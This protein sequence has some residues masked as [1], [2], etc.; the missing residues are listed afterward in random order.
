[1]QTRHAATV[2]PATDGMSKVTALAVSSLRIA[3]ATTDRVVLLYDA[4]SGE[5]RDRIPT[6]AGAAPGG[7]AGG[8][9]SVSYQVRG[10][11]FSPDGVRL[12][13][14]QSD[15][16]VFVFKLGAT[17]GEKKSI[18]NKFLQQQPVTA[19]TWPP[20]SPSTLYIGMADGRVKAGSLRTNKSS[21]IYAGDAF[22]Y[23]LASA[24][25]ADDAPEAAGASRT[26]VVAGHLDGT[27]IVLAEASKRTLA[28]HPCPP[29]ALAVSS[30]AVC[31]AGND[32][33]VVLYALHSGAIV[34]SFDF[35]ADAGAH[36]F[37][38]AAFN[39][40][41]STVAVGSFDC[42][43]LF[44]RGRDGHFAEGPPV[45]VTNW[46]TVTALAWRSDG[47][48]LLVGTL[49][50]VVDSFEAYVRRI[51]SNQGQFEYNY[52]SPSRV[53]LK[54]TATGA[55]MALGSLY[56]LAIDSIVVL[57]DRYV[58]AKTERTTLLGDLQTCK[59]S[60]VPWVGAGTRQ[61][62]FLFS[63]DV[64]LI[65]SA[66]EVAV[67]E[68]GS[69]ELVGSFRTPKTSRALLSVRLASPERR[70]AAYLLDAMT[71]QIVD[72]VSGIPLAT[73]AHDSK[74]RW[75]ALS[76]DKHVG[77]LLIRDKRQRLLAYDLDSMELSSLLAM[78]A[79]AAWLPD[80][81]VLVAQSGRQ[82]RVWYSPN[83][84]EPRVINV[85]DGTAVGLVVDDEDDGGGVYV[86]MDN[87]LPGSKGIPLDTL[88]IRV[89][90]AIA[91]DDLVA[92][93]QLL[94]NAADALDDEGEQQRIMSVSHS[95]AGPALSSAST[96]PSSASLWRDLRDAAL[97]VRDCAIAGRCYVALGNVAA[98]RFMRR[99]SKLD[100]VA[101]AT[102]LRA[103]FALFR[104]M[105]TEAETIYLE[106]AQVETAMNMYQDLH[107]WDK[108]I[109]LAVARNHP[110]ADSLKAQYL[111]WLL[112]TGQADKAGAMKERD[113]ETVEAIRL[114]ISA[115]VPG[116][117]AT[118]AARSNIKSMALLEEI[119]DALVKFRLF[120]KAGQIYEQLGEWDPA[121]DNYIRCRAFRRAVELCR[122]SQPH[123]VAAMEEQ[124]GDHLLA[125][126][127]AQQAA[128]HFREAGQ[129]DKALA[130]SV[131]ARA[132][133][134][135]AE[136]VQEASLD[137]AAQYAD[138][139]ADHFVLVGD[140][141]A[142]E[143]VLLATNQFQRAIDLRV[144]AGEWTVAA[145]V[146]ERY[147]DGER[148]AAFES[149]H[150]A[151]MVASGRLAQA[152]SFYLE[153]G[154]ASAAVDMYLSARRWDD[155]LRL[156]KMHRPDD[157]EAVL[158]RILVR[159]TGE[160]GDFETAE[161]L[162]VQHGRWS[163]ACDLYR[164]HGKWVD[165]CELAQAQGG[166]VVHA[167][168]VYAV[169]M[170]QLGGKAGS[171]KATIA[172]TAAF[173]RERG[174]LDKVIEYAIK[175]DDLDNADA[176]LATYPPEDTFAKL[177][178]E[179]VHVRRAMRH[180]DAGEYEA[181][182]AEYLKGK[183][184]KEAIAM[185]I[186]DKMLDRA[187]ALAREH[188]PA[189]EAEVLQLIQAEA[190]V[191]QAEPEV[192]Q[193]EK[194]PQQ[195]QQVE[196][197]VVVEED[198]VEAAAEEEDVVE[199]A[200]VQVAPETP[201][202]LLDSRQYRRGLE[203]MLAGDVDLTTTE[204]LVKLARMV[205]SG[206]EPVTDPMPTLVALFRSVFVRLASA[207]DPPSDDVVRLAFFFHLRDLMWRIDEPEAAED[208][209]PE[210]A[211]RRAW[212]LSQ[213][214]RLA[215]SLLR[216]CDEMPVDVAF[217]TAGVFCRKS[218]WTGMAHVFFNR[219][220][221]LAEALRDTDGTLAIENADF[222]FTD[223]P[224]DFSLPYESELTEAQCD[225]VSE[226]MLTA[227]LDPHTGATLRMRA[228]PSCSQDVYEASVIC[229]HCQHVSDTCIVTGYPVLPDASIAC[230]SCR[231]TANRPAWNRHVRETH[232]CPW[233]HSE[234]RPDFSGGSE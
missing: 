175:V 230:P 30:D 102:V 67:V 2:R 207:M 105:F 143:R 68:L 92:A 116:R 15:N 31:V 189:S 152:E 185:Y 160:T 84:D 94:D 86:A 153:R 206:A 191:G 79:F 35:A 58:V 61:D 225:E 87:A 232:R 123:R 148:R 19:V 48:R 140:T 219:Y 205:A 215:V 125:G 222:E 65:C 21:P 34:S 45:R 98:A 196:E 85:D 197:E 198:V 118:L 203:A 1:M 73:V 17:W 234:A 7:G 182:E 110:D 106:H 145:D 169:C 151:H 89:R 176:W 76:E 5:R 36:E 126:G 157:V 113:G 99:L 64:T 193:E 72:L 70:V 158:Q 108:A 28:V 56:D 167:Q 13:V 57:K 130:A 51:T 195:Q 134:Q 37:M 141:E 66:G 208:E 144:E 62:R 155:A 12:A 9:V 43:H 172:S 184:P 8:A 91:Q 88:V 171:G 47:A 165:A 181:A 204:K 121:V 77:R 83:D 103:Q 187:L 69:N 97:A 173:A 149:Q 211:T 18:C 39:P 54:R 100:P 42:V 11:A 27:L 218:G 163:A 180:E 55:R 52:T 71:V 186:H 194:V 24:A 25:R 183:R 156:C 96:A 213:K 177:K 4:A 135:A 80:S 59:L 44:S 10:L 150:M 147:L 201:W 202:A 20:D 162:A 75:L 81:N 129:M 63:G 166:P 49:C 33:R 115:G 111:A 146:A 131:R 82:L 95:Q 109:A 101:D 154:D 112:E 41:G 192:Q 212:L 16:I 29:T 217:Y 214:T 142:A 133:A 128:V 224:Y 178:G 233:C 120:E 188:H 139:L 200:A 124:W 122:R 38:C 220:L 210:A 46:Y 32:R 137:V 14:A 107:Q 226:W 221:D 179:D 40:T 127:M 168:V 223:I 174:V 50:G 170:D 114:Y 53:V 78:C 90:T 164:K 74:I 227:T 136:L 26:I 138:G 216:Y 161:R 6:K 199:E 228:C 117:A 93:M 22:V 3:V 231:R 132:W 190:G 159:I 209:A 104:R 23:S 229:H 60:E 119:A